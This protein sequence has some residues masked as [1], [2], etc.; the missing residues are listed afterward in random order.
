MELGY[1]SW[2]LNDLPVITINGQRVFNSIAFDRAD[3]PTNRP[4]D[5][6]ELYTNRNN[7]PFKR[8]LFSAWLIENAFIHI[9]LNEKNAHISCVGITAHV[10]FTQHWLCEAY[11]LVLIG[12]GNYFPVESARDFYCIFSS[13]F[14]SCNLYRIYFMH[15]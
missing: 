15:I 2:V 5:R 12:D 13:W 1:W 8:L 9:L 10:R 14:S 3:Q 4:T 11:M 7:L 6:T